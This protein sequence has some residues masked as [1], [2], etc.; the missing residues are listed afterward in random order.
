MRITTAPIQAEL[1]L[2]RISASASVTFSCIQS[3]SVLNTIFGGIEQMLLIILP[4]AL[5]A[6]TA[7]SD[8]EVAVCPGPERV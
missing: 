7:F 5:S 8:P 6:S 1:F 4:A 2:T 3:E